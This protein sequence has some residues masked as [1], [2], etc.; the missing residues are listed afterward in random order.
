MLRAPAD[1]LWNGGIGTYV[2]A[3]EETHADAGDKANDAIRADA[4]ELRVK[5]VGEGGNLG[6]TQRGR[7]EFA[8]NGGKINTDAIDNS[9]GVDCSDH[10]VNIKILLDRL[11]VE[12]VVDRDARDALL[13]E[14]TD[15][16]SALVLADNRTQNA[17]LGL[18]R[19]DAVHD[20][21]IHARMVA[22]LVARRALDPVIEGLPDA[23]GFAARGAAGEGLSGPELAVVLAHAKLDAK[24]AVLETDLPDLPD[25][26]NRL[27]GYFPPALADR[28]LSPLA[29]HPLRR[30]IVATS[31]VNQMIDRSGLTYAFVLG[32]ATGATPADALRAFL[33]VSAVF[34]LPDLWARIDELPGAVPVEPVDDV[35]RET[36]RFLVRAAQW[37]LTRRP[38]PLSLSAEVQQFAPLVRAMRLR[39]PELLAGREAEAVRT[40]VEGLAER[41]VPMPL[42]LHTAGLLPGI[43]LFDAIEVAERV[44]G[45]PLED[46]V[47]MYFTLK[48]RVR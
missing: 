12:G 11:V 46:I 37:L 24:S 43:G 40:Q 41:G 26:A 34:D 29:Q 3:S 7:I 47:R 38:R 42:A 21:D 1:L 48:D 39:L 15:E 20:L 30:E 22:D 31:L 18:S 36:H 45:V 17:V 2:K 27:T 23:A 10:E 13:V 33:I 44:P 8:R 6:L 16:V 35:V 28:H 14:M 5:V 4:S 19:G 25:V 32:E 9:A